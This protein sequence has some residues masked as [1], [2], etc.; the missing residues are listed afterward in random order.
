[1]NKRSKE[2]RVVVSVPGRPKPLQ[3]YRTGEFR[4]STG[5]WINVQVDGWLTT[6]FFW[7]EY[8]RTVP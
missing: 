7:H 1:M 5:H 8:V 2:Q 4:S 6:R 3:G